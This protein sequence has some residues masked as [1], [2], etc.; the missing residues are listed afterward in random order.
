MDDA[1]ALLKVLD[2]T[3]KSGSRLGKVFAPSWA[4]LVPALNARSNAKM[5]RAIGKNEEAAAI[6]ADAWAAYLPAYMA[7]L[8]ESYRCERW[9]F[10]DVLARERVTFVCYCNVHADR[11]HC[12]RFPLAQSFVKLGAKY[13]GEIGAVST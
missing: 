5:L 12:H 11:P 1:R 3:R 8:R 7:E 10:D 6:E 9:A 4:I 13:L 2:I